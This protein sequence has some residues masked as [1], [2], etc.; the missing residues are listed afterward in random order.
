[1]P[2]I[3]ATGRTHSTGCVAKL[4]RR[5]ISEANCF[6]PDIEFSILPPRGDAEKAKEM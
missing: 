4:H 6:L 1:M 3:A 2:S 5:T